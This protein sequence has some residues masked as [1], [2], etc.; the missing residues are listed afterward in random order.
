MVGSSDAS[1]LQKEP[2]FV[3]SQ[4]GVEFLQCWVQNQVAKQSWKFCAVFLVV[5]HQDGRLRADEHLV[6]VADLENLELAFSS[7]GT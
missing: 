6:E 2:A 3:L 4:G 1:I 5:Q 7:A